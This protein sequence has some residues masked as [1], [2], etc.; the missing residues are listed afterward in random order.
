[1]E[2]LILN[3][4]YTLGAIGFIASSI[5]FIAAKK[6]RVVEDPRIDQI[7]SILPAANCG[8]CGY[9][10]CRQFAEASTKAS[11]LNNLYCP[12]GG[13]ACMQQI[14][15]IMGVTVEEKAPMVAVLRCNG[16][17]Q[18]APDKLVYD[19][20]KNCRTAH[21]LFAG[22]S[23]CAYGCLGFGDCAVVCHFDALAVD[24]HT[25]LPVVDEDKCTSCGACVKACPRGLFEIRPKGYQQ[26]QVFVACM[27]KE[28]GPQAK[29]N[30]SVA[31]IGCTKCTKITGDEQI[32]VQNFLSYIPGTVDA[33]K[34]GQ[35]LV[36]CCPTKAIV[37][38][39]LTSDKAEDTNSPSK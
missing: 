7:E 31:C 29:K 6:F 18:N 39:N 27:N 8:G 30:C 5:L 1:M 20:A 12:V 23:G 24:P 3:S 2:N 4:A 32:K 11:D 38:R 9:A 28:K 15:V 19:G 16:S 26:Q 35:A 25:G 21:S 22:P 34:F 10:G 36:Q 13:S 33:S 37:G 17:K 14:A